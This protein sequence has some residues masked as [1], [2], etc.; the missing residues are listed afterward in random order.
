MKCKK[1]NIFCRKYVEKT[2]QLVLLFDILKL[3]SKSY[4][5]P[6]LIQKK[7]GGGIEVEQTYKRT[8]SHPERRIDEHTKKHKTPPPVKPVGDLYCI[9]KSILICTSSV[10]ICVIIILKA[11][12]LQLICSLML[13]L[14]QVPVLVGV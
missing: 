10:R 5:F 3:F 11:C 9:I 2:L 1:I 8:D 4:N 7:G 12:D 6:K 14:K 13:T